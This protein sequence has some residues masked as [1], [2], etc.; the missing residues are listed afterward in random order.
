MGSTFQVTSLL[1]LCLPFCSLT[2]GYSTVFIPGMAKHDAG[3]QE[4]QTLQ[5]D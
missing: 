5:E 3:S 1:A 2:S 4:S